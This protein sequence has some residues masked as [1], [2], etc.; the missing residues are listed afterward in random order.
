MTDSEDWSEEV[1]ARLAAI[2]ESSDDAI[3]SK[4]LD[5]VITSWNHAA[6]RMFGYAP[7]E[8]IGRNITLIIPPDRLEEETRVLASIRAGRRVEHFETIRVTK[9]GRQVAVSLTVS[10]VKD[11][12]GRIIGASKVARD[13]SERRRGEIAQA[14]LAAIIES[15]EDAI[16]SKTL[17]GVI[18]SW[19]GA[20]ERVFG[21]TAAEAIG[22]HI[23]LI[24]P[25]EYRE[26]ER[27]VLARLRRGDRIDHFE[28]VR[29]RKD[30]QLLDV[31]ITVSP[32]RD[33]RGTIVGAS[34]V[35]R[36]ISAQ[37][38]LEQARQALL[39]RE[40]AARTEAEDL[41]RSKDQ[42]LATLSHEL[43][44][45]LNAIYGWARMLEGGGLDPAAMRNATQAILRNST[46]QVQL[47]EDLFDVSR[48][49]TGNMRLDVRPMNVFAPLEAALDTVRP[50][51]AAK[52]IRLDTALDPRATPIMG[53]P[54][55]IQQ[56]V[57]NLLV[58]AVKFTP[59]GGRVELR[60]RRVNSHI[61]IMVSDTGEGIAA[62]QV[63][64]LFERFRQADTG[65][66]RRHTGLGIG[67]S[68]VKHLVELHG[69]TVSGMSAGLGQGSTFTVQLPVSVVQVQPPSRPRPEPRSA[70]D[71]DIGSVK[72][73]SLRDVH[74]LVVDDD[75]ESR[76]LASL[77]LTNAG[78]E[79]R[80]AP[81][82]REAMA[83][84]EEWPPDVLV[85]DLEM[86]EEDGFSLLRRARRA[87]LLRNRK[88]PALALTAY[89]RSEDR[90][91]VL[92]AGFNLHL[93]KPAD[94]TEL[95]LAVASLVGRTE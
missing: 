6:E 24:I 56:V 17:D 66:T 57:W 19:N 55:R 11:S 21:W 86:P 4:T 33:G 26:E 1:A 58:N 14:R 60:L 5:G 50:A 41:N 51:A 85:S 53:D 67:L 34:K 78:A 68:L 36:D 84:L 91:R 20:A 75:E 42:F 44:T 80:T 73:V 16:I 47:I 54:G 8:A 38:I 61:Q 18:T 9:D 46:I 81:S 52:G 3:V 82:A 65:P 45:P 74:V 15:S 59:K 69:G 62:D 72:P 87:S 27:G 12:S 31:S 40:Q 71:P 28:T 83:L 48:V 64:H 70:E 7:A 79:T 76:E 29:Q 95:V 89:G 37:R 49:I 30:G 63:A 90:V 88:L 13:V 94:P 23:T 92:A 2:V 93:A 77:V 10:P 25:E 43:R 32:I 35:A 22:Q 39:E